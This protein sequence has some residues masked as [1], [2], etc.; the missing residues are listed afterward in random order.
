MLTPYV[1][2]ILKPGKSEGRGSRYGWLKLSSLRMSKTKVKGGSLPKAVKQELSNLV[3]QIQLGY[4][5]VVYHNFAHAV[6]VTHMMYLFITKS[7]VQDL[8]DKEKFYLLLTCL[9]HDLGHFGVGNGKL[10]GDLNACRFST[11]YRRCVQGD[12][13][14][15][16]YMEFYHIEKALEIVESNSF[17]SALQIEGDVIRTLRVWLQDIILATDLANQPFFLELVSKRS[18]PSVVKESSESETILRPPA[19]TLLLIKLADVG[20][21]FRDFEIAKRWTKLVMQ[22]GAQVEMA[23]NAISSPEK[24]YSIEDQDEHTLL[25]AIISSNPSIDLSDEIVEPRM[26]NF[27][28]NFVVPMMLVLRDVNEQL[29]IY[30]CKALASS[31]Q[32]SRYTTIDF[33]R[34]ICDEV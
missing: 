31:L 32:Q 13:C 22:E 16:S 3:E 30:L 24:N 23:F 4:K 20:N 7:A 12:S 28:E 19:I 18:K 1:S 17:F 11:T 27:A 2:A 8:S 15:P 33:V 34:E 14:K 6:D 9:C 29:F 21:V 25:Q 10:H 26:Q 5:D